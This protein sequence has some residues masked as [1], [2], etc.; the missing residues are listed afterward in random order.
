MTPG[1]LTN[2][3]DDNGEF[4][5]IKFIKDINLAKESIKQFQRDVNIHYDN[6]SML[7]NAIGD[8][9]SKEIVLT[10]NRFNRPEEIQ[11]VVYELLSKEEKNALKDS[12]IN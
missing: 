3:Y 7:K 11:S 9:K 8:E 6:L 10:N 5:Y 1:T 2:Y 12:T 4:S